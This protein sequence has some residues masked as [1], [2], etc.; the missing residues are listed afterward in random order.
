MARVLMVTSRLPWPPTEGHQLRSWHLLRALSRRHQVTLLSCLRPEDA[1]IAQDDLPTNVARLVVHPLRQDALSTATQL[2]SSLA[3]PLPYVVHRYADAR[4]KTCLGELASDADLVH[5]DMLP[6]MACAECVPSGVPIIYN[7]HN[8]EHALLRVRG[9]NESRPL[10]RAFLRSQTGRLNRFEE[11]ACRRADLVLACSEQDRAQ[12]ATMGA[13]DAIT[14][15]NGVDLD[16][17]RPGSGDEDGSLVFV[18]QMGWFPNRDGIEWF[19]ADVLPRVLMHRPGLRFT[20]VG[21]SD[22]LHV[23]GNVSGNVDV[24]GFVEDLR[25]LLQRASVYVVPLRMG[26]GTRLKVLEAMAFGKAIVTTSIGSEG[27]DLEDG[28]HGEFADDA[29]SFAERI[30]ALLDDP[31]RRAM[32]GREARR[33]AEARYGWDAIG[34]AMLPHYE[35]L[36]AA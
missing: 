3:G 12:L 24:S 5:I 33:L 25:P 13:R 6:L 17:N 14:V 1:A 36:L 22:G 35:R 9:D 29:Q 15:P 4:L 23:P 8:V 7:A 2:A 30:L 31:A 20:L 34:D 21:K 28:V 10:H 16:S 27:I 11:A 19:L 18:G 26:S 32:L